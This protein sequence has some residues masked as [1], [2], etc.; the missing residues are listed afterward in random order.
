M[1]V[2]LHSVPH[3]VNMDE[4]VP[5][6]EDIVVLSANVTDFSGTSN[7]FKNDRIA[8]GKKLPPIIQGGVLRTMPDQ[9]NS[10]GVS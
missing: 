9:R 1:A 3:T 5:E 8:G 4:T 6:E 2:T 10:I 7:L